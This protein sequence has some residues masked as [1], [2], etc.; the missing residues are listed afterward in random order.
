MDTSSFSYLE[1]RKLVKRWNGPIPALINTFL[2]LAF[3]YVTWW[4]F[5]DPRGLMRMYTPYVGYMVCR[6]LLIIF[7][8]LAYIFDYW[9]FKRT[10]LNKTHPLIKGAVLTLVSVAAMVLLIKGFFVEILGN[11][12]IA[13]F[14]PDR[15]IEMGITDFYSIEYAAEAIMMFAAIASWLAP[16]WVV[17]CENAPWQKLGQPARGIT[18]VVVTFFISMIVYF[19]TMHSHMAI[20]FYP[21]QK[22]TAICPPYWEQFANTV[23]GNFHIAWIMCCTV[24]VWQFET[25]WERY[26]FNLIKN[27]T[28]RRVASFFGIIGIALALCFFLFYAQD[29]VWG[30][31]IRGTRR[32]MAP[33]WRWLHVGEMAIFW[34]LPTLYLNFYCG[35]WPTKFSRPVNVCIRTILTA[36]MA[37]VV[38]VIYYKTS[39]LFLGT[40]KG[41]SHPQQFPMIPMIWLINIFLIN[42]WFM[43][44]WPGWKAIPKTEEELAEVH[45]EIV[46]SDVKWTPGI[47]K[48]LAVGVVAGLILYLVVINVLPW[49]GANVNII[50]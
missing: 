37:V 43:D 30:E 50:K 33:D 22:Y 44:G 11:Y 19:V 13:Y 29:L 46:A 18:I 4:I 3:F 26:P 36:A 49:I 7:I 24:V 34:L 41:F 15:L 6:W 40:Q 20:L 31:T 17:A 21:W 2:I 23:S 45:E 10:W 5:Q 28:L 42:V 1:S 27:D 14:N 16:S 39:H 38:Y 35:N 9:P 32:L 47:A 12:G 8:W 25:I 48:G